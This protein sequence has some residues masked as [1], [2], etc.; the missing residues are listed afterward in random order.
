MANSPIPTDRK[1]IFAALCAPSVAIMLAAFGISS[2]AVTLPEVS[3]ALVAQGPNPTLIVSIYI[4]AVTSLVVP[5]GR[6]GDVYGKRAILI[7]G[8]C[9]FTLGAAF[10]SVAPTLQVLIASRFVQGA[11]AAAMMAMPLALVRDLVPSGQIGRWMGLLGSMTAIG[12]ASGPA[13]AGATVAAFGWRAVYVLQVPI[14]LAT[15]ILCFIWLQAGARQTEK[16]S[17]DFPGAAALALSLAAITSL[18]SG[19]GNGLDRIN[20]LLAALAIGALMAFKVIETRSASPIIPFDLLRSS[21][22]RISFAMNAIVSFVMMGMLVIG[23]FFLMN[24]LGLTTAQMGLAMSVGPISAALSGVPA[25]RL[26]EKLGADHAVTAGASA[27]ALACVAMSALPYLFGL[28][29]FVLAFILLAPS[30]QVFLAALNTSVMQ[31]A[32]DQQQGVTSAVL[33]LSRNFGFILGAGS[34]SAVFWALVSLDNG[35]ESSAQSARFAMA[36]SFA[37]C[38]ICVLG[39][40]FLSVRSRDHGLKRQRA[41]QG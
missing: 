24:G 27:M 26:T 41:A 1:R 6:A 7:L 36:G 10:A 28:V 23:P 37:I 22:L 17:I 2:A 33:N 9:F 16:K 25:G 11:G 29:G 8:L 39:V 20:G 14:A 32:S 34:V 12:T 5:V 31:R 13:I 30:Y 35:T 3:G 38:F 18:I 19:L 21:H 15:L 40:V 4:L